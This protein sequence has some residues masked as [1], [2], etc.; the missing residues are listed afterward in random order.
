MKTL[1]KK[2][3]S[4]MLVAVMLVAAMPFAAFA[5]EVSGT[6]VTV[7]G[8]LKD[9]TEIPGYKTTLEQMNIDTA[10]KEHLSN[11]FL[12]GNPSVTVD[13]SKYTIVE[14][15]Y[16]N[17]TST[18]TVTF[19]KV[20]PAPVTYTVKVVGDATATGSKQIAAPTEA[21]FTTNYGAV[22]AALNNACLLYTSP[23][24]RD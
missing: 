24:P 16:D 10:K 9:G 3:L 11:A 20:A 15:K 4:L 12:F 19:E 13:T 8:Q 2:L 18:L 1:S 5:E 22:I 6:N 23:S 14:G 17:S 21:D 7:V